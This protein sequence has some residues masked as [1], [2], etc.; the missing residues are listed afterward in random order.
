MSYQ[1]VPNWSEQFTEMIN[2]I[3]FPARLEIICSTCGDAMSEVDH[4]TLIRV[5]KALLVWDSVNMEC[6]NCGQGQDEEN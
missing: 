6:E 4:K 2:A 5:G 3:V 1:H